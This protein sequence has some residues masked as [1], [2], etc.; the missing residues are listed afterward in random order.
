M[1]ILADAQTRILVQGI[2]GREAATFTY[3]SLQY[4]ARIVAGVTPGKGGSH[5]HDVPVFDSV[6]QA[7][8]AQ[9][10]EATII[11][12][13]ARFVRDAVWEALDHGI[14]LLAIIMERIPR[15]DVAAILERVQAEGARMI[16]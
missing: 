10:C 5:V 13:Q 4:G 2:T 15:S 12:V 9:P 7:L 11:S 14:R 8:K 16:G 6:A 1:A 3:E